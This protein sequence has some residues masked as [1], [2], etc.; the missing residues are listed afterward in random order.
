MWWG[1]NILVCKL[2][3]VLHTLAHIRINMTYI[4]GSNGLIAVLMRRN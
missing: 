2:E 4:G 3:F 1:L